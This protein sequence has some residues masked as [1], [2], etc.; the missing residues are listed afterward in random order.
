MDKREVQEQDLRMPQFVDAKLED[1]E[2]RDDGVIV[3]KD[4]WQVGIRN[5]VA[6]LGMSREQYE[7][8][9]VVNKVREYVR[10]VEVDQP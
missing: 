4:R 6:I 3:R 5:I 9:D 10:K 2:F 7:I 1:L 8:D